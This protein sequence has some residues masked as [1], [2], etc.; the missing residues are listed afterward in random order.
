MYLIAFGVGCEYGWHSHNST[1]RQQLPS[2]SIVDLRE[3]DDVGEVIEGVIEVIYRQYHHQELYHYHKRP[4]Q[5][6]M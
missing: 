5:C 6:I 2:Q 3:F 1:S 4:S